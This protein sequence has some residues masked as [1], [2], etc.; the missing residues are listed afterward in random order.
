MPKDLPK[1][2]YTHVLG[3]DKPPHLYWY[4][5][6]VVDKVAEPGAENQPYREHQYL[7]F[8]TTQAYLFGSPET[9]TDEIH[10]YH[11]I[12]D[13]S[14]NIVGGL[15]PHYHRDSGVLE[16]ETKIELIAVVKGWT[17]LLQ[18]C[19]VGGMKRNDNWRR[20][21]MSDIL[22]REE[23]EERLR[24]RS[25]FFGQDEMNWMDKWLIEQENKQNCYHV[26]WVEREG[27]VAFRKGVGFVLADDWER[28]AGSSKVEVVLG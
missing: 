16:E 11:L 27:Q 4:P 21:S 1:Y 10:I 18:R 8:Q 20:T 7:W 28:L 15:E 5:V 6:S 9:M 23:E 26:L 12:K 14:G 3:G 24:D 13:F 22:T 19:K 25:S 2:L 17:S